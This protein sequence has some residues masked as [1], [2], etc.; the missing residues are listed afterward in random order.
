M[1]FA[2]LIFF[3]T[4]ISM[5]GQR[6]HH[7]MLSAQG[8]ST[9]TSNGSYVSQTI[10]Q[11]SATGNAKNDG[12]YYSQGFQQSIWAGY[13]KSTMNNSITTI[14][15]PNPFVETIHFQFSQAIT[16]VISVM[17]FDIR[18]R[19]VFQEEKKA[20]QNTLTIVL[21]LFASSNYLVKLTAPNYNYFTQ[22]IKKT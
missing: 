10:G 6:L 17:V 13:I 21:P 19:L 7:Q 20:I 18:G 1:R 9:V 14:T 4:S 15:Y 11:Q 5:Y 22:I 16:D 2:A 12:V 3:C 8:K